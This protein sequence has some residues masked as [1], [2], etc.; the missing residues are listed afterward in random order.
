MIYAP[1]NKVMV[2]IRSFI[3]PNQYISIRWFW[4]RW[5]P[6]IIFVQIHGLKLTLKLGPGTNILDLRQ[7]QVEG[8]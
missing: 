8:L 7:V 5:D 1:W 2:R 6:A 3:H 4:T